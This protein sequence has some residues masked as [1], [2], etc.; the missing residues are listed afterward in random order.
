MSYPGPKQVHFARKCIDAGATIIAGHHPHVLQG[1][2]VFK[3][4]L[5]LYSLGNF[6][7]DMWQNDTRKTALVN[8][9][10]RK[11]SPPALEAHPLFINKHYQPSF[12]GDRR[13]KKCT[14][15]IND[16]S[17]IIDTLYPEVS[18]AADVNNHE[19]KYVTK[20]R[21]K[22]RLHRFGDYCFF[23]CNLYR[24]NWH[25]LFQSFKRFMLRKFKKEE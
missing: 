1:F 19:M 5:I 21:A 22:N 23:L 17:R 24:Y 9:T 2:E 7:F 4:G 15:E 18:E 12:V 14:M 25:Y 3:S 20:A 11:H 10:C 8:I 13:L 16:L 6:V